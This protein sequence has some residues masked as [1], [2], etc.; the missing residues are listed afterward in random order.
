MN[1]RT[2]IRQSAIATAA[3]GIAMPEIHAFGNATLPEPGKKI[4][5]AALCSTYHYLSHAYHIVGR[6]LDGFALYDAQDTLHKPSDNFEISSIYIEQMPPETDLGK[7]IAKKRGVPQFDSIEKALCL[8]GDQLAVDAV[9]VIAE[10]GKYPINEKYQT[11][12]PRYDYIKQVADVFKKSGRSVPVFN[13]KHLSYDR[14]KASEIMRWSRELKF[15]LM[16]GSSLPIT[17]RHP[18]IEIPLDSQIEDVVVLSRGEIEIFGFH[19]LETLQAFVERRNLGGKPQGVKAVTCLMGE[20][21]WKAADAGR[22]SMDLLLTAARRS[23][24]R[25]AGSPQQCCSEFSPPPNRPTFLKVPIYFEVEY[26]DGFIGKVVVANGY[27]DDTSIAIRLKGQNQNPSVVSTNVYLPAP[28]GANFFNPLVLRIEDFFKSG[29]SPYPAERT[30]LTGGILDALL[31]S[32]LS[33][34]KRIETPDLASIQ[35]Q[36][37]MDSGYIRTP[38]PAK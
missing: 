16:A 31:D 34:G 30:Q 28:P 33:G 22:W 3:S 14:K 11:L 4:R 20:D 17:W 5:V 38:W 12:Y 19:A 13:D 27:V 10:H 29:K 21:V 35:Y 37:P 7:G 26:T 9:L 23:H 8:G 2:M 25:N 6:F 32:R 1:R 15:P 24:S 18:E 36:A